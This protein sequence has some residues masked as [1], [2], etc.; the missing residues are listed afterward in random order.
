MSRWPA[1][2]A[3][4][5]AAAL[6]AASLTAIG[7]VGAFARPSSSGQLDV[8]WGA[9]QFGLIDQEGRGVTSQDLR[10]QV[11]VAD[12]IYTSCTD[13]CPLLS[14]RMQALQGRLRQEQLL[15]NGVQLLSFSVDPAYDTPPVLKTY[16]ER[17]RVDP[18]NWRFL[19]GAPE[20]V[21][22]LIVEGFRLGV[23]ALPPPTPV[24]GADSHGGGRREVMHS[25]R[26]VLIDRQWRVRALYDGGELDIDRVVRDARQLLA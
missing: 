16:A 24:P 21:I 10:G 18:L 6:G 19:T 20:Q 3:V 23:Q 15:G 22:P 12:F 5:L 13:I 14:L 1:T 9:P 2:R 8:F 25:G 11:V 17:Y 26:F 7:I 4:R